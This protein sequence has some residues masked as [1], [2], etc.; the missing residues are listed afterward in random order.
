MGHELQSDQT[1]PLIEHLRELRF[2]LSVCVVSVALFSG[3]GFFKHELI[4][5][6]LRRPLDMTLYFSA[7][8]GGLTF[9]IKIAIFAGV[10][11]SLPVVMYQLVKF[12]APVLP[13]QKYRAKLITFVVIS[14]LLTA[15]GVSFGY[16]ISLPIALGFL[17]SIVTEGIQ[18]LISA[19]EY[20]NFTVAYLVAFALIFQLPLLFMFINKIKPL[21]PKKLLF[22]QKWVVVASLVLAAVLTPTPDFIN[23]AVMAAPIILLYQVSLLLVWISSLKRKGNQVVQIESGEI[24]PALPKTIPVQLHPTPGTYITVQQPILEAL[25][26]TPRLDPLFTIRR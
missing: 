13:R 9:I 16:F 15:I 25:R 12:I 5:S 10:I 17:T 11:L 20:F 18:P 4:I 24:L 19:D 22:G 21:D 23:Q 8:A 3:I 26:R 14:L 2:R 6:W 1:K 7:P